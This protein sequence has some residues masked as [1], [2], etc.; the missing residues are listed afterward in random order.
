MSRYGREAVYGAAGHR[1]PNMGRKSTKKPKINYKNRMKNIRGFVRFDYDLRKP[2]RPGQ[3]GAITKAFKEIHLYRNKRYVPIPKKRSESKTAH[4][5]RTKNIHKNLGQQDMRGRLIKGV[6][7]DVPVSVK[8]KPIKARIEDEEIIFDLENFTEYMVPADQGQ[9]AD[10]PDVEAYSSWHDQNF[11]SIAIN[12][13]GQ[14][15]SKMYEKLGDD[16]TN[17]D[18][19]FTLMTEAAILYAAVTEHAISGYILRIYN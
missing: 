11:D 18:D 5:R 19:W 4:R 10:D 9:L 7:V 8:G 1:V 2:L 3:K 6:F 12:Y 14:G 13:S 15:R 17:F 16:G